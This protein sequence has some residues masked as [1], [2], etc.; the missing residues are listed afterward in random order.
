MVNDGAPAVAP[1]R[2][3]VTFDDERLVADAGMRL[4][5]TLAAWLGI[6]AL[7]DEAVDLGDRPGCGE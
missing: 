1:G 4:P 6:E 5:E 7:A 2:L 3:A